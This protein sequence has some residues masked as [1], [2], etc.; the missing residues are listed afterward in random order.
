MTE[1][2]LTATFVVRNHLL[3]EPTIEVLVDGGRIIEKAVADVTAHAP[4]K[5]LVDGVSK[6]FLFSIDDALR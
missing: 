6:A 5:P 3:N 2:V 1:I 4:A